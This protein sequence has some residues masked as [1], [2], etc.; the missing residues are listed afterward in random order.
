MKLINMTDFVLVKNKFNLFKYSKQQVISY[1]KFLK[2]PLELGMFV[3]V[4]ESG[5]VMEEPV[6]TIGGVE[7]YSEKYQKAKEKVLFEGFIPWGERHVQNRDVI[8]GLNYKNGVFQT[9]EDLV[10]Y[11][12]SKNKLQ[13]TESA[14][15]KLGLRQ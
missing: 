11:T 2:R 15:K 14:I 3:P 12:K 13:L 10:L 8:I 7:L 9:I 6:E 5:N 4:D 1:A